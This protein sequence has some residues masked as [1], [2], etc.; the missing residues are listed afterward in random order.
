MVVDSVPNVIEYLVPIL[1]KHLF[2]K[3]A[4][5]RKIA[6]ISVL[7]LYKTSPDTVN[8]MSRFFASILIFPFPQ[9]NLYFLS[10]AIFS[11]SDSSVFLERLEALIRDPDPN[12]VLNAIQSLD[13]IEREKGNVCMFF[14][15]MYICV[16]V[17]FN[18]FK[19]L[20]C[21]FVFQRT[22]PL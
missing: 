2:D 13:E 3:S 21:C 12:V 19:V 6:A 14:L 9:S 17:F 4:Y 1:E 10:V 20:F 11:S 8:G 22:H 16:H 15:Y 7:K 18:F 5:V